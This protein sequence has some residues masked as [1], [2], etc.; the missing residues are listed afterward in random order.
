VALFALFFLSNGVRNVAYST[1]T[2]RV[3][4]QPIRA[5]FQS[6]QSAVQH[7]GSA[8]GAFL[9]SQLL[10]DLPGGLLGGMPRVVGVSM[11]LSLTLP[12]MF[13]LVE[14]RLQARDQ[15]LGAPMA[16]VPAVAV[17]PGGGAPRS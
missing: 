13:F 8:A 5:R 14:R 7:L 17:N 11:L 6:F 9:S 2:S 12:V 10:T 16:A 1:L 15:A 4:E 3:P